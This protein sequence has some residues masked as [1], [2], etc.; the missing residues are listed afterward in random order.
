M[1]SYKEALQKVLKTSKKNKVKKYTK[2]LNNEVL[3]ENIKAKRNN[4][5]YNNSLLDGFAFKSSDT[6]KN[7][8]FK[9]NGELAVG[10]KK[11]I[12]YHKNTCYRISTGGKL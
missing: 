6:V 11:T 7:S 4:P 10:E 2:D 5:F 8:F 3:A 1:T 12:Q 9:I